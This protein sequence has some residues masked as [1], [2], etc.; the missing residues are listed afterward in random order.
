MY[1]NLTP[2]A[3]TWTIIAISIQPSAI[4]LYPLKSERSKVKGKYYAA[5]LPFATLLILW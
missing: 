1:N 4:S 2:F 5:C 3:V